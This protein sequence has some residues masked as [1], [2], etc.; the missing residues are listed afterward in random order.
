[1]REI[2]R[3]HNVD[4]PAVRRQRKWVLNAVNFWHSRWGERSF[5]ATLAILIGLFA[6][7]AAALL[8]WI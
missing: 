7:L 8:H 2:F 1:M 5:L 3:M 4:S 6:G